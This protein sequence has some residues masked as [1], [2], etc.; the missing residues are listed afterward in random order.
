MGINNII[1]PR[2]VY[3]FLACLVSFL[4]VR[5]SIDIFFFYLKCNLKKTWLNIIYPKHW[6]LQGLLL[7]HPKPQACIS[8]IH[9]STWYF[10]NTVYIFFH[11]RYSKAQRRD[12]RALA[13]SSSSNSNICLPL[14]LLFLLCSFRSLMHPNAFI[15]NV[16]FY[17]EVRQIKHSQKRENRL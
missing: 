11:E 4:G 2:V 12:C 10:N 8:I 1:F 5:L 16:C 13:V 15:S 7:L 17:I 3:L 6:S 14:F 9:I